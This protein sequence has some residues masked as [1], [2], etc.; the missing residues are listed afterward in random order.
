MLARPRQLVAVLALWSLPSCGGEAGTAGTAEGL[1]AP[2]RP[3]AWSP[4]EVY[5]VGG[6]DADDWATFGQV[7]R[8]AFDADG[9]LYVLDG[10]ASSITRVSPTG[11]FVARVAAAGQG[12]GELNNPMGM[13]V[14]ADGRIAVS[15]FGHRGFVLFSPEGEWLGNVP[16]DLAT[17]G[18]PTTT[19]AAH[20]DGSVLSSGG[21]RMSMSG[22]PG[23]SGARVSM[24]APPEGRPIH[25]YSLAGDTTGRDVYHAWDPPE[26][27]E[28]GE[29]ELTGGSGSGGRMVMRMARLQAFEPGL[30][31]GVLPDGRLV[32]AD[33]SAY[34]IKIVDPET[35]T[36]TGTLTRP[37]APTVVD[38]GIEELERARQLELAQGEGM[39]VRAVGPGGGAAFD[40]NAVRQMMESRVA[41]MVFYPEIP[42]IEALAVD[43]EGRIWVQRASGTPG[44]DGPTDVITAD[45]RYLGTLPP[46]GLRIPEAFGPDGLIAVVELDEFDVPTIRVLRVPTG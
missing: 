30:S 29:S 35:G 27:P 20:P 46:D 22:G 36:V 28:G 38:E 24:G 31:F 37:I 26:P 32:V 1:D 11:E 3:L 25:R 33:S 41:S 34:A 6:F 45:R 19:L 43:P 17:E 2:D 7:A 42:V 18:M 13:A 44:E 5:S 16:V 14:T 8:L 39:Q 40:Q 12:P 21:F 23:G 10:Q 9:Y 4:E 15:D